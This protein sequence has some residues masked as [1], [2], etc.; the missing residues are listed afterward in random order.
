[1]KYVFGAVYALVLATQLPHIWYAYASLERTDIPLAQ[2]TALGAA[3]AFELAIGV[4]TYRIIKGSRRRWTRRGLA[5]F[6]V[7][8]IVANGYYYGWLPFVFDWL[9]PV[10]AT[11]AL[12]LALALFAEEFGVE[13]KREERIAKRRER[14]ANE[15]PT[16]TTNAKVIDKP[17]VCS[18]CG[19]GFRSQ[20]GLSGHMNAHRKESRA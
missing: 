7:A 11:L 17:F 13:V 12:P 10:F 4:F 18:I 19:D 20:N 5:F 14:K 3:L 6:I 8:S 15:P 9:M 2:W 16:V 1:M